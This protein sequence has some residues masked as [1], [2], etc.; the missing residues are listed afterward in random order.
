MTESESIKQAVDMLHAEGALVSA[1]IDLSTMT[2]ASNAELSN[3]SAVPRLFNLIKQVSPDL[4]GF[5]GGAIIAVTA[6]DGALGHAPATKSGAQHDHTLL[7]VNGGMFG[8]I[9]NHQEGIAQR[10]CQGY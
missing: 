6:L 5:G 2:K 1:V 9:K 3:V 8:V 10:Q 7:P 4:P